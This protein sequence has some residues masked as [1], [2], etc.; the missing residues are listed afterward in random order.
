M[1]KHGECQIGLQHIFKVIH[2]RMPIRKC[3]Q[4]T[5]VTEKQK[6]DKKKY[7]QS[8]SNCSLNAE[9]NILS[10]DQ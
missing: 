9:K 1:V 8:I 7:L 4:L 5:L 3:Y 2:L 6:K 10:A